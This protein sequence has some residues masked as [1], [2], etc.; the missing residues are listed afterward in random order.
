[1]ENINIR[2][3]LEGERKW[4]KFCKPVKFLRD[5]FVAIYFYIIQSFTLHNT[6]IVPD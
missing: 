3:I 2:G 1:M 5:F 6:N 4:L